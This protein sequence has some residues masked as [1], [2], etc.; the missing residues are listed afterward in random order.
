[1]GRCVPIV[2]RGDLG[3]VFAELLAVLSLAARVRRQLVALPA[4][5]GLV[6]AVAALVQGVHAVLGR[7]HGV[8]D[9]D[10]GVLG[11]GEA[12]LR[13]VV[14]DHED[15]G[16]LELVPVV[17]LPREVPVFGFEPVAGVEVV[18]HVVLPD[19]A[20]A[21]ELELVAL[22]GAHLRLVGAVAVPPGEVVELLL[23]GLRL[24]VVLDEEDLRELLLGPALP[25][26]R[27]RDGLGGVPVELLPEGLAAAALGDAALVELHALAVVAVPRLVQAP[28]ALA[29][30]LDLAGHGGLLGVE[31]LVVD[32]VRRDHGLDGRVRGLVRRGGVGAVGGD[33]VVHDDRL[34]PG[35]AAEHEHGRVLRVE[36]EV[37]VDV[38]VVLVGRGGRE[39]VDVQ[40]ALRGDPLG[41]LVEVLGREVVRGE[42]VAVADEGAAVGEVELADGVG[43]EAEHGVL[44]V[45]CAVEGTQ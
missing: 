32:V 44:L 36:L 16:E 29:P 2:A 9:A 23:P 21:V 43:L 39:L 3:G 31:R 6:A 38:D 19:L 8:A 5:T 33:R 37:E 17:R 11:L 35:G 26:L 1:M 34:A 10:A 45:G 42:A 14:L 27:H 22:L 41:R 28:L 40:P 12:Q 13:L 4:V 18:G 24:E 30:L 15:P 25:D 7:A 20:L